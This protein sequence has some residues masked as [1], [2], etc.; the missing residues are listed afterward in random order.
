MFSSLVD[1]FCLVKQTSL[2]IFRQNNYNIVQVKRKLYQL[3]RSE[4]NDDWPKFL[5]IVVEAL[6]LTPRKKLGWVK[7]ADINSVID[8]VLVQKARNE[9]CIEVFQEPSYLGLI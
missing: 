6:N 7:P 3:M 8:D 9:N 4:L 5:P 1:L 2:F